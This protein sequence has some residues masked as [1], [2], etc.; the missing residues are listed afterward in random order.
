MRIFRYTL[1]LCLLFLSLY[2]TFAQGSMDLTITLKDKFGKP[3]KS[4]EIVFTETV[5][6]KHVITKTDALGKINVLLD[7]GRYWKISVLKIHDWYHWYITVPKRGNGK[8]QMVLTYNY[9]KYERETRPSVDRSKLKLEVEDQKISSRQTAT[10]EQG[11]VKLKITRADKR[12]PLSNFPVQITCYKLGKTFSSKTNA[13]GQALF[14]VPNGHEYEI[15]IDGIESYGYIDLEPTPYIS[16][17]KNFVYEPTI[18]DEK[19]KNDTIIQNLP[20]NVTGTTARELAILT[21]KGNGSVWIDEPIYLKEIRG[22]KVYKGT[23]NEDGRVLFL[24]PKGHKYMIHGR[25]ERDIDVLDFTRNR[26]IGYSNK[27]VVYRPNPKLQYPERFI[28]RPEEL[29]IEEFIHFIDKQ[30]PDPQPEETIGV[31]AQFSSP[32]NANSRQAVLHLGFSTHHDI[33]KVDY[34]SPPLNL[35]FVIDRSG[36][37][38]GYDR[39]ENLKASLA[40]FVLHLRTKDIVSIVI[41]NDEFMT[42]IPAQEVGDN[43]QILLDEINRV[44]ADGGTVIY[45]GLEEGYKQVQKNYKNNRT[46]RVILLTDGY[47]SVRIDSIVGMSKR[48]NELGIECSAVGVG[49]DYNFALLR[50]LASNGGGLINLVYD[51]NQL[52][53]AFSNE[54]KSVL[55]PVARNA[56]VEV[57]YNKQIIF[58]QLLGQ[59]VTEKGNDK[60]VMKLK[61]FYAGLDQHALVKFKLDKPS[62][63]IENEPV[64]IKTRY[65]DLATKKVMQSEVQAHLTWSEDDGKLEL[66]IDREEKKLYAIA[67]MNQTLK[68]M[69]DSFAKEDNDT[70][71]RVLKETIEDMRELYPEAKETDVKKLLTQLEEYYAIFANLKDK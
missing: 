48:Y 37:M 23:T 15:D 28:P 71:K 59:E 44:D 64:T 46:N 39:I 6:K 3:M 51:A 36:S 8:G 70:A 49:E 14:F 35:S 13:N 52:P 5:S 61:D 41:F 20:E 38:A 30:L 58:S 55:A 4:T 16:G 53:N 19:I 34:Q 60:I 26:G 69:A 43:K 17:G 56:K 63:E 10:K 42:V 65:F 31:T 50:L 40:D 68:A 18:V 7:D 62:K 29:V 45:T 21:V 1:T 66:I 12:T 57:I 25:Y 54:M 11:I 24:V 9:E 2:S 67:V 33:D 47:G 22:T 27:T 32:V